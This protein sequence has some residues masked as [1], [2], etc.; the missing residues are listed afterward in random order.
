MLQVVRSVLYAQKV[1][2]I[3]KT[4]EVK[5]LCTQRTMMSNMCQ[6]FGNFF[7]ICRNYIRMILLFSLVL[8]QMPDTIPVR[9]ILR[10]S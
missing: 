9:M 6:T 3:P 4:I 5:V 2:I 10:T 8:K 7:C 1:E